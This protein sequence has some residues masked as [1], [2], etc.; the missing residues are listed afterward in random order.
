M[1]L[2]ADISTVLAIE[3]LRLP[4]RAH[5]HPFRMVLQLMVHDGRGRVAA[6]STMGALGQQRAGHRLPGDK[7][8]PQLV[9]DLFGLKARHT[10]HGGLRRGDQGTAALP[11]ADRCGQSEAQR[12]DDRGA[13]HQA[14][15]EAAAET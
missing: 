9:T 3:G 2:G 8:L 5:A 13:E 6:D 15:R 14:V 11:V 12:G 7:R 10:L 1:A 4:Q